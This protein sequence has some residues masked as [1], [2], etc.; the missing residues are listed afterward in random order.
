MF[1]WFLLSLRGLPM[2]FTE[3]KFSGESSVPSRWEEHAIWLEQRPHKCS[4]T[5]P[6]LGRGDLSLAAGE[7]ADATL[8]LHS[9]LIW[10]PVR[11][12]LVHRGHCWHRLTETERTGSSSAASA[13]ALILETA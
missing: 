12:L 8:P 6:S 9:F 10:L 13:I 3:M 5:V 4:C 11:A 2:A 7:P 1:L